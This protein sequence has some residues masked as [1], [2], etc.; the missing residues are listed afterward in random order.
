MWTPSGCG[1][2]FTRR[3]SAALSRVG[4][5]SPNGVVYTDPSTV[6]T[7]QAVAD[8][9]GHELPASYRTLTSEP[10]SGEWL[11]EHLVAQVGNPEEH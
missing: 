6:P 1:R 2:R 11:P 10:R 4:D 3:K 9:L 7:I 8:E 5:T